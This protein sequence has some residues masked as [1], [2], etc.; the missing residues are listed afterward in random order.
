[1]VKAIE[2]ESFHVNNNLFCFVLEIGS[3]GAQIGLKL[4]YSEAALELLAP[5]WDCRGVLPQSV[6][7]EFFSRQLLY[8]YFL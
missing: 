3:H 2:N 8:S 5:W 1:M 6:S 4:V 7:T